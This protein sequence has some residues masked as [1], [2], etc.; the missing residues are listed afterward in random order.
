QRL[1]SRSVAWSSERK[2]VLST[3]FLLLTLLAYVRFVRAHEAGA[4]TGWYVA[5]A[6]LFMLAF[7]AK[8]MVVTLPGMLLLLDYW[9]LERMRTRDEFWRRV[10]EKWPF[11]ALA[12]LF[13]V[14]H[15]L[16][17]KAGGAIQPF[18]SGPVGRR[19]G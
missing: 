18:D 12:V 1:H 10:R 5:A 17:Q 3:L 7:L 15:V 16:A 8:P 6:G 13:C 11:I 2:D 19:L 14:I 4:R 9:P